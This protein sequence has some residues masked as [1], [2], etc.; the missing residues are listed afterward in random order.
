MSYDEL[1]S[2]STQAE[3]RGDY[4][5]ALSFLGRASRHKQAKGDPDELA[6]LESWIERVT[7]LRQEQ[8]KEDQQ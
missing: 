8:E 6:H 5:S 3:R 2:S 7:E 1:L 4:E